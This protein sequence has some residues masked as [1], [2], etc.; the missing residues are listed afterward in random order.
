MPRAP[1][2]PPPTDTDRLEPMD[3]ILIALVVGILAATLGWGRESPATTVAAM[4]GVISIVI[5]A[6]IRA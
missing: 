4:L 3:V 2:D 5:I 1:T 6:A